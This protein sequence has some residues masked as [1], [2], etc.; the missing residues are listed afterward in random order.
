[1]FSKNSPACHLSP[2]SSVVRASEDTGLN[3]HPKYYVT[4]ILFIKSVNHDHPS[5]CSP[6]KDCL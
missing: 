6:E 2:L 3:S 1:M 4:I 5:E